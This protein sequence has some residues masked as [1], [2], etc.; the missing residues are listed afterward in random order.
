M[1]A[2]SVHVMQLDRATYGASTEPMHS[3]INVG[4]GQDVTIAEL[5]RLVGKVVGY[6]GRIVFDVSKPDG[7]PRKLLDVS[8]LRK[9]GWSA[10]TTLADGLGSAYRAYLATQAAR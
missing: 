8:R 5:A 2:A 9:L 3:H 4:T 1:A 6:S 7:T 10:T